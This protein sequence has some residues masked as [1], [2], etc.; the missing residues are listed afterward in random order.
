LLRGLAGS[1]DAKIQQ[2][3]GLP[4]KMKGKILPLPKFFFKPICRKSHSRNIY[5]RIIRKEFTDFIP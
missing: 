2:V 4:K 1:G 5:T 3:F